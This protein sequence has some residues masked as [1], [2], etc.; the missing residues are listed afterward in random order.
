MSFK[1]SV[2]RVHIGLYFR[3]GALRNRN[4]LDREVFSIAGNSKI[5]L[6]GILAYRF[7]SI[8]VFPRWIKSLFGD[9]VQ[10]DVELL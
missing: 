3:V 1:F 8:I 5:N 2:E 7:Q 6:C 10:F 4:F 9:R